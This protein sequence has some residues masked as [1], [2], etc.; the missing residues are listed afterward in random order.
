MLELK[1][2]A[3][4][5]GRKCRFPE[6]FLTQDKK[7]EKAKEAKGRFLRPAL[8]LREDFYVPREETGEKGSKWT[9]GKV[10]FFFKPLCFIII[11]LINVSPQI[12]SKQCWFMVLEVFSQLSICLERSQGN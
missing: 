6:E 8:N 9:S 2:W 4:N 12:I 3:I 10:F 1:A 5:S 7:G 11:I